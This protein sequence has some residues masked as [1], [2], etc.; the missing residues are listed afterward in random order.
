P[1]AS[2]VLAKPR[3]HAGGDGCGTQHDRPTLPPQHRARRRGREIPCHGY[4]P[5]LVV[6]S[7]IT[8]HAASEHIRRPT[9]PRVAD[10][11]GF[12]LTNASGEAVPRR[13][14]NQ[15]EWDAVNDHRPGAEASRQRSEHQAAPV[16]GA[17]EVS[18]DVTLVKLGTLRS[19][20]GP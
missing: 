4:R 19:A 20:R 18:G 16:S 9:V 7:P 11:R 6:R 3:R 12:L 8:P 15:P 14:G 1:T 5:K 2:A 10:E 17:R 13:P